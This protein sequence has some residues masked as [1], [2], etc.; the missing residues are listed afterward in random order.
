MMGAGAGKELL[1]VTL[2]VLIPPCQEFSLEENGN[3]ASEMFR[4]AWVTC[5]ARRE[6]TFG[7]KSDILSIGEEYGID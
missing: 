1:L 6:W 5:L 3:W 7:N 2:P 4:W